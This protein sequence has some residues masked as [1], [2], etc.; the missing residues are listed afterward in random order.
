MAQALNVYYDAGHAD[1]PVTVTTPD[2]VREVFAAVRGKYPA[3]SAV[4]L[5]IVPAADPWASELN[6]GIDGDVGVLR[7]SGEDHPKGV[8][9]KNPTPSNA[10]PVIY[11]YVTADTEFPPN[12]EVPMADVEAAVIDYLTT[13]QRPEVVEW[14]STR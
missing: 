8:Y 2:E 9:S 11:Y 5:T 12:A 13:G 1:D 10:E 14:Q 7:Y 3:G 4:L 6:A